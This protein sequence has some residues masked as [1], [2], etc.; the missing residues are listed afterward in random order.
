[1]GSWEKKSLGS[2]KVFG[3]IKGIYSRKWHIEKEEEFRKCKRSS[4]KI[5]RKDKYEIY[6]TGGA[7]E[8]VESEVESKC[9]KV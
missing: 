9:G 8:S 7:R 4:K 1:M 3:M 5:Q 2:N 6:M